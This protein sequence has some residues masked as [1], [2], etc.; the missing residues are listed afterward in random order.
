MN[1]GC[2]ILNITHH[3]LDFLEYNLHSLLVDNQKH[4]GFGTLPVTYP[5]ITTTFRLFMKNDGSTIIDSTP[6]TIELPS[7][8]SPD[9][10]SV[11]YVNG[12][13]RSGKLHARSFK[14]RSQV[15]RD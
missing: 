12:H 6:A 3:R 11:A 10:C 5:V 2:A 8:H 9:V 15:P 1:D 14:R 7:D 13:L 4:G